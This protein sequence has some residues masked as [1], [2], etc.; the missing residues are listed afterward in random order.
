MAT[1]WK[2]VCWENTWFT[3]PDQNCSNSINLKKKKRKFALTRAHTVG[4]I[5]EEEQNTDSLSRR[6]KRLKF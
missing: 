6:N 4:P 2:E 1:G 3:I 5:L